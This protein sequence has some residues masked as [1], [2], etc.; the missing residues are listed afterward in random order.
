ME[1]EIG[2]NEDEYRPIARPISRVPTRT[3]V[4]STNYSSQRLCNTSWHCPICTSVA[5]PRS[6]HPCGHS[7]CTTCTDRLEEQG[8]PPRKKCPLCNKIIATTAINYALIDSSQGKTPFQSIQNSIDTSLSWKTNQELALYTAYSSFIAKLLDTNKNTDGLTIKITYTWQV[9][10]EYLI[11]KKIVFSPLLQY[12]T[13]T[14]VANSL[15]L[16]GLH[17][18]HSYKC[19]EPGLFQLEVESTATVNVANI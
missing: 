5:Q 19:L 12:N 7:I 9:L 16:L 3:R 17:V 14:L 1:E 4:R 15:G 11:Q 13:H 2:I 10:E 6:L 18:Q 8:E